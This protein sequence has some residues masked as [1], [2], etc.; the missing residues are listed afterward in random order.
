MAASC[1]E[2]EGGETE[3]IAGERLDCDVSVCLSADPR[4]VPRSRLR[5]DEPARNPIDYADQR[6]PNAGRIAVTTRPAPKT[7]GFV[8]FDH[9]FTQTSR[10]YESSDI[11]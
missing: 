9:V 5:D 4:C 8:S 7:T 1:G 2:R 3:E 10:P 6:P 11:P